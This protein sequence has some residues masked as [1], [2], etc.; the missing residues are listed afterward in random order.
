MVWWS[1]IKQA[2]LH[3]KIEKE[4]IKKAGNIDKIKTQSPHLLHQFVH[5]NNGIKE[6]SKASKSAQYERR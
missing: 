3:P 2:Q 6:T 5:Y 1:A 4:I